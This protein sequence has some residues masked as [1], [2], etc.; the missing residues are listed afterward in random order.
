MP[1]EMVGAG[2]VSKDCSRRELNARHRTSSSR[3]GC[4]VRQTSWSRCQRPVVTMSPPTRFRAAT[5]AREWMSEHSRAG[6]YD[7]DEVLHRSTSQR[8]ERPWGTDAHFGSRQH[9]HRA[10]HPSDPFRE[11]AETGCSAERDLMAKIWESAIYAHAEPE[12]AIVV[13]LIINDDTDQNRV[14]VDSRL[15]QSDLDV[16]ERFIALLTQ[17]RRALRVSRLTWAG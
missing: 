13:M 6:V 15:G 5:C 7:V 10:T 16:V 2:G 9:H 12:A 1:G 8:E 14:K 17:V 11:R 3:S 4:A